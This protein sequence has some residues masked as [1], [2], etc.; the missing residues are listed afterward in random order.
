MKKTLLIINYSLF[1]AFAAVPA[2]ADLASDIAAIAAAA[3]AA[4]LD[5]AYRDAIGNLIVRYP[6]ADKNVVADAKEKMQ[7][8]LAGTAAQ[9]FD[10]RNDEKVAAL[11]ENYDNMKAKENSTAN[12]TLTS[13]SMLA[14]GEG[15]MMALQGSAEQNADAD[16][17]RDM[18][19][20]L[21]SWR[22]GIN[23]K[24]LN[25]RFGAI[26]RS[27]TY[28]ADLSA[29][30]T[31]YKETALKTKAYKESLDMLPGIESEILANTDDLYSNAAT[32]KTGNQFDTALERKETGGTSK[33]GGLI[34]MNTRDM[35][36]LGTQMFAGGAAVGMIGNL[37][38][39]SGKSKQEKSAEIQRK[40]GD[41][42]ASFQKK[43]QELP[44]IITPCPAESTSG[45]APNCDC[46]DAAEYID[47]SNECKP[48]DSGKKGANGHCII[49]KCNQGE[50]ISI[51]EDGQCSCNDDFDG[52]GEGVNFKCV[53]N[54]PKKIQPDGKCGFAIVKSSIPQ[55]PVPGLQ[56]SNIGRI[57]IPN[58]AP[59]GIKF[60]SS[61]TFQTNSF[62]LT[63]D[64]KK[65]TDEFV[66]SLGDSSG[67]EVC[68]VV[69]GH[70]SNS[71]GGGRFRNGETN[72][73]LSEKRAAAILQE[74][75]SA[76]SGKISNFKTLSMGFGYACCN[77]NGRSNPGCQKTQALVVDCEDFGDGDPRNWSEEMAE[78]IY[79]QSSCVEFNNNLSIQMPLLRG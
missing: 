55:V 69:I 51:A 65:I 77:P 76:A 66:S 18:Q 74:L 29:L 61:K 63:E 2:R 60:D 16:A 26:A 33:I 4:L 42:F 45:N 13:V 48:C 15:A 34:E 22:C 5:N 1:I 30:I 67:A 56:A 17:A 46:G 59:A 53:C 41:N 10:I 19:A 71:G 35:T 9:K 40:Y 78:K 54:S 47:N 38:I 57:N 11:Q 58:A 27:P 25:I 21:D 24:M 62:V 8:R 50:H 70:A 28:P 39:N 73:S 3:D 36:K 37:A 49:N 44:E 32:G 6:D 79:E 31:E 64:A 52:E 12:K 14:T 72:Q 20:T 23:N 43:L 68:M 7:A 75:R